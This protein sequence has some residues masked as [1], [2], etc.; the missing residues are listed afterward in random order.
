MMLRLSCAA[1]TLLAATACASGGRPEPVPPPAPGAPA[2]PPPPPA[3]RPA[4]VVRFGPS[5]LRYLVH[6]QIHVE[7]EFQGQKSTVE[8]GISGYV[9]VTIVG[10]ADS[11]G[12]SAT[13]TMDSVVPDS[14]TALPPTMNLDALRG[15][16]LRGRLAPSGEFRDAVPS[17]SALARTFAQLI[18][19]FQ[20]FFPRIPAGG[21]TLGAQW[22]DTVTTTDRTIVEV[23]TRSTTQSHA[24]AWEQRNGTR[25]LRLEVTSNYTLAGAGDQ[26]GQVME[27]SGTGVRSGVQFLAADGR[28]L[29][30]EASDSSAISIN[31][32]VQNTTVPVR[33]V[34]RSTVTVLP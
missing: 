24:T 19:S 5:A 20:S 22:T 9:S 12:Y 15:L 2:T 18:G 16:A 3:A 34:S 8:R 33:Q 28:Y 4:E 17:D 25:A 23:T 13:L 32:P 1:A 7:Q 21:L 10:P 27:I 14:G 26:G 6:Q 30:G 11:V 31:L 29:G